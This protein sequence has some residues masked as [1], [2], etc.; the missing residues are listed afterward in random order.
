MGFAERSATDNKGQLY[1][2][3]MGWARIQV[4]DWDRH[5]LRGWFVNAYGGTFRLHVNGDGNLEIATAR[6]GML[7]VYDENGRLLSSQSDVRHYFEEFEHQDEG[8]VLI[9]TRWFLWPFTNPF[10]G[11]GVL[12]V[13]M[14][15][16]G[17]ARHTKKQAKGA[18]KSV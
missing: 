12:M 15:F 16:L 18:R 7:Y 4:Y 2:G 10:I 11:F 3:S 8:G 6:Q 13:G 9:P 14:L 17:L 5:F 1:C